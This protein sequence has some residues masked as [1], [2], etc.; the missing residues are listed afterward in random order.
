[1]PAELLFQF[2]SGKCIDGFHLKGK[3]SNA[4]AYLDSFDFMCITLTVKLCMLNS[5]NQNRCLLFI[6]A[7]H[8]RSFNC[9]Q[10]SFEAPEIPLNTQLL[11]VS[12]CLLHVRV[13]SRLPG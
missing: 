11:C 6:L 4:G 3:T 1:M 9:V 12:W 5:V 2:V 8:V 10:I 7:I 13:N